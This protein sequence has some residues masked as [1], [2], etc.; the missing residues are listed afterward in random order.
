MS[1]IAVVYDCEFTEI[2]P[3]SDLMSIGF[4][5]GNSDAELYI[6]ITD[7]QGEPSDFVKQHVLPLFGLHGPERLTRAQASVRIQQWLDGLR[8]GDRTREI[9]LLSD[10]T[11]D[12][13]H[14]RDLFVAMPGE[15]DWTTT[16]NVVGVLAQHLLNTG[17]ES[18]NFAI[19]LNAYHLRHQQRHHALV[20][21]RALKYAMAQ[22]GGTP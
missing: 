14:L 2:G 12:W 16:F 5:A 10:S 1:A 8:G 15:P 22:C 6:E 20:D 13:Q 17:R 19:E 3:E 18:D 4:V 7:F 9:G 21:A 11:W